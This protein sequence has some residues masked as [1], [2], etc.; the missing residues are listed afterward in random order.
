VTTG[1]RQKRSAAKGEEKFR[2]VAAARST[3]RRPWNNMLIRRALPAICSA[4]VLLEPGTAALA[5]YREEWLSARQLA[6]ADA[7]ATHARSAVRKSDHAAKG[8]SGSTAASAVA[9]PGHRPRP[10]NA[11][12]IAAFAV[13]GRPRRSTK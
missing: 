11:D 1:H 2:Q 12:P 7:A 5:A 3:F 9:R 10:A 6:E 13:S 8:R 4:I